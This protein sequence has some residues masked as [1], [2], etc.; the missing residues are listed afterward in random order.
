MKRIQLP[1]AVAR[2]G[3][4]E[5]FASPAPA[6]TAPAAAADGLGPDGLGPDFQHLLAVASRALRHGDRRPAEILLKSY[7]EDAERLGR[8]PPPW[9]DARRRLLRAAEEKARRIARLLGRASVDVALLPNPENDPPPAYAALQR[10]PRDPL[11]NMRL[12]G[13]Q[14]AA[15]EEIRAV[16]EA[17]VRRLMARGLS[18]GN[19][20]VDACV[21]V[22]DPFD[23]MPA[24]LARKRHRRYLPWVERSRRVVAGA[25]ADAREPLRLVDLVLSVLID[26]AS[27]R[28]LERRHGVASGTLARAFKAAL[29]D[30][31]REG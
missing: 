29:D 30:Y 24:D 21:A 2:A 23:A 5:A 14:A 27:I 6:P 31:F 22:R 1:R 11:V 19:T 15:A 13:R 28:A 12:S 9:P 3:T 4:R 18:F 17:T 26:R 25:G 7:R 10:R 16:F 20:R 8:A